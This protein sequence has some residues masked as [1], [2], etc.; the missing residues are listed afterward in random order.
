MKMGIDNP[1]SNLE[2][3]ES[4]ESDKDKKQSPEYHPNNDVFEKW[5]E[6]KKKDKEEA[7]DLLKKIEDDEIAEGW[8][9]TDRL[10]RLKG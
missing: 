4:F 3:V 10:E 8:F 9:I 6:V 5:D 2:S 1:L 7:D